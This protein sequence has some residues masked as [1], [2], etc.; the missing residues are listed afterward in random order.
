[1]K[2]SIFFEII[3][4]TIWY[5][6]NMEG[7]I[8]KSLENKPAVY[9]FM[10]ISYLG[11]KEAYYI[12]STAQLV[13]RI[14]SHRSCIINNKMESPIFY[15]SVLKHGW[16]KFKF[17]VLE[18]IDLSGVKSYEGKRNTILRR[19]QYYMDLLKPQNNICKKA[20]SSLGVKRNSMFS[21]NLSRS[22]R[23]KKNKPSITAY[24]KV[25]DK[26]SVI[27]NNIPNSIK[28][29]TKLRKSLRSRG[30]S[31]KIY[32]KSNNLIN[33]FPTIRSVAKYLGVTSTTISN[34]FKTGKSY[35][36]FV[37]KFYIKNKKIW[38]CD[39]DNKLIKLFDDI[40]KVSEWSNIPYS[41]IYKYVKSSKLY[42]D[43]YY[44]YDIKSKYNPYFNKVATSIE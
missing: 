21:I 28:D 44:F 26:S 16:N 1:M 30:I 7:Y 12:G 24:Y 31:V 39:Y 4:K 27:I 43:K 2:D 17:G 22:R 18:Y 34:I 42:K 33:E 13:S 23:G 3:N 5:D 9:I 41:T 8:S 40:K 15:R 20:G 37:Y 38:V 25:I 32:D 10:K 19:E 11:S 6:I 29:E 35:D 14:K 36:N